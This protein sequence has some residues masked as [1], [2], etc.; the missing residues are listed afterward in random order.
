MSPII[1]E[2][3]FH[4]K[5][6]EHVEENMLGSLKTPVCVSASIFVHVEKG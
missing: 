2:I 4:D 1:T 5:E 3:L 6:F